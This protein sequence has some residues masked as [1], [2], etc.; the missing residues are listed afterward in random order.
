MWCTHWVRRDIGNVTVSLCWYNWIM[1]ATSSEEVRFGQHRAPAP[2][3]LAETGGVAKEARSSMK[4]W[5]NG[6]H[7]GCVCT[8]DA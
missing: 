4:A 6:V 1:T 8:Q 5:K 2:L 3:G 7:V